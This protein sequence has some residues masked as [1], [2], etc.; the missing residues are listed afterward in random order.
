MHHLQKKYLYEW[1]NYVQWETEWHSELQLEL[2]KTVYKHT[3]CYWFNVRTLALHLMT[4]FVSGKSIGARALWR[5]G[6]IAFIGKIRSEARMTADFPKQ[7]NDAFDLT[8][9]GAFIGFCPTIRLW[10]T[11]EVTTVL[12]YIGGYKVKKL[13]QHHAPC[14]HCVSVLILLT[15]MLLNIEHYDTR[16]FKPT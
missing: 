4:T 12:D 7:V 2:S 9:I 15:A 16:A 11:M 8:D 13:H 6:E 10:H 14:E 3:L 1:F 5:S